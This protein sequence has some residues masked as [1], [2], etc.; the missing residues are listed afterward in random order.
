MSE[1]EKKNQ[2]KPVNGNPSGGYIYTNFEELTGCN[3]KEK[4]TSFWTCGGVEKGLKKIEERLKKIGSLSNSINAELYII[5]FPW[6]DTLNF[7]QINFN[8]EQYSDH[9][10]KISKCKN[11]INLF[12]E[13][14]EIKKNK[15]DWL[16][17]L[18]LHNDIHLTPEANKITAN[19]I[20]KIGFN[21]ID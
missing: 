4:K 18:Y 10:C 5:I 11:V 1:N 6:P 9:L 8:W 17:Y 7:G 3:T 14:L 21:H 19:K 16:E 12:P 2:Y 13:F 15:N 20:L